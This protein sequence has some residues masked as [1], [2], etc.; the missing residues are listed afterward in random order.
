[1]IV[2]TK[3]NKSAEEK[4]TKLNI[5]WDDCPIET[6]KGLA[7][8]ALVVKLQGAW[9]RAGVIPADVSVAVKDH[10]PGTR[11]SP[12]SVESRVLA[13][14]EAEKKALIDKLLASM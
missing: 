12:V 8:Q 11:G 7:L 10:A 14:S 3:L 5:S 6:I 13:L 9:R 1:M 4:T 2:S